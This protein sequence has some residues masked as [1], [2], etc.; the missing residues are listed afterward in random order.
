MLRTY[1]QEDQD[2]VYVFQILRILRHHSTRCSKRRKDGNTKETDQAE[3]SG[4][5]PGQPEQTSEKE[6][7]TDGEANSRVSDSQEMGFTEKT[8]EYRACVK[9]LAAISPKNKH[10]QAEFVGLTSPTE[11]TNEMIDKEIYS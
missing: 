8:P 11:S 5:T 3:K 2:L 6:G 10:K 9:F 7:K 1:P 4:R